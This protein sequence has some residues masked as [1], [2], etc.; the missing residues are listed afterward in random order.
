MVSVFPRQR[1]LTNRNTGMF[2]KASVVLDFFEIIGILFFRR[3][4][5]GWVS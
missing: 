5:A 4:A 3:F 2:W 1:K